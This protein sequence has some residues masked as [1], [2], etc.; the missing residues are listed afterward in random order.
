MLITAGSLTVE[1]CEIR[2]AGLSCVKIV[3]DGEALGAPLPPHPP[4]PL[5]HHLLVSLRSQVI[6]DLVLRK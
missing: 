1:G 6:S 3:G 4:R 5:A 2:N